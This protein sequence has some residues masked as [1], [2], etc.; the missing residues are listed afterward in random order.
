MIQKILIL[1]FLFLSVVTSYSDYYS[2]V[3]TRRDKIRREINEILRMMHLTQDIVVD[4][5]WIQLD[6]TVVFQMYS[7]S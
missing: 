7:R 1:S 2:L 6:T 5:P 3:R 4:G